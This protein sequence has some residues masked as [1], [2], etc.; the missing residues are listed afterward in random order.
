MGLDLNSLNAALHSIEVKDAAGNALAIDA[1]GNLS[2]KQSGTWDIGTV[3]T[4]T[5]VV[6]VDDNAGSLTVDASDLDIRD[7]NSA[8]DSISAVQSGT[9][10]VG[11]S[12]MPADVDI[13]D[14]AYTQDSVT[15]HLAANS[16]VNLNDGTDALAINAD[17]SINI[18]GSVATTP[19]AY[20]VWQVKSVSVTNTAT[21]LDATPLAGRL[22]CVIQ[23]LGNQDAYFGPSNAVTTSNGLL[24][25]KGFSQEIALG[26]G[27]TIYGITSAS[28]SDIRLAEY[29]S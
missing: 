18:Q 6:H 17:G 23:N 25:A 3:G 15:A 1:S 11:V 13:R 9:W 2:V 16:I 19:D 12:S 26:D 8:S 5:N 20:D 29:A 10:T 21:Q 7:L 14:L 28:T 4:I 27:A 22:N 24:I